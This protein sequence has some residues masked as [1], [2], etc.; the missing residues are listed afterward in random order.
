MALFLL[1]TLVPALRASDA[2]PDVKVEMLSEGEAL[3]KGFELAFRHFSGAPLF[4]TYEKEGTALRTLAGIRSL[5]AE[6]AV[7]VVVTERGTTL[8]IPARRVL[9]L[10]D[11]RPQ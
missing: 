9:S 7:L 2:A 6:G 4:L 3:A 8:A 1:A 11:E 5:E 10:T